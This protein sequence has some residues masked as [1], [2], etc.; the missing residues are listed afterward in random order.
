MFIP[1]F[2]WA[3]TLTTPPA[4]APAGRLVL[5]INDAMQ[6][7]QWITMMVDNKSNIYIRLLVNTSDMLQMFTG[8][9]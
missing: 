7:S 5:T 3:F 1:V 2:C 6:A 9:A 8:Q 4:Y